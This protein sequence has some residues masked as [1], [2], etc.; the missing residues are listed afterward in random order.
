MSNEKQKHNLKSRI[1]M[2][3]KEI[4][5]LTRNERAQARTEYQKLLKSYSKEC[6]LEEPIYLIRA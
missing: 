4:L 3:E 5:N 1:E 2:M 6:G